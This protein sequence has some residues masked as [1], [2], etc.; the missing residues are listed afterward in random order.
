MQ[1]EWQVNPTLTVN[2]GL[3]YDLQKIAQPS[4]QNPDAQLLA[5]GLDTSNVP[6]DHNNISPR[7]GF[8]WTPN[9]ANRTV[10]R[11]GYGIFYGRTPAIMIGTAHSNNGINVQT[12]SFTGALIPTYPNI[13]SSIPTGVTLPKP[14]IFVFDPNFQNPKVQQ[15]SLGIE[16]GLTND[17][18]VSVTYQYVKGADLPRSIDINVCT[19]PRSPRRS[20]APPPAHRSVPLVHALHRPP[21]H[22]LRPHDR[23]PVE[24]ELAVQRPDLRHAEALLEQLADAPRL[25]ATRR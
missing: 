12:L 17:I 9:A 20:S 7:V 25:D 16:R 14:T 3:R 2:A 23:V 24:R 22:E 5:A 8:A 11:G 4:V 15:A 19:R 6:E 1:D 18:A 13:Y 10:V 21:V